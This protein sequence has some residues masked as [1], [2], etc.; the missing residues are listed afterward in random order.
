MILLDIHDQNGSPTGRKYSLDEGEIANRVSVPLLHSA[1]VMYAANLRLGTSKSKSR[2][3]VSGSSKKLY[4]QKGTGNARAGNKRTPVRRGGGHCFAKRPKDWR[5]RMPKSARKLATRMAFLSKLQCG[6]VIVIDDISLASPKTSAI[7]GLLSRLGI[8]NKSAVLAVKENDS[9]LWK[10]CRNIPR[11]Q[12]SIAADLNAATVLRA[13]VMVVT[14]S[15][16]DGLRQPA[17]Q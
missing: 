11:L 1:V 17:N 10:S 12:L 4:K 3:E 8:G 2:A 9:T 5:I 6:K 16:L 15:A 7:A 13:A 14:A